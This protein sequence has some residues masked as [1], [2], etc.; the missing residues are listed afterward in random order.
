MPAAICGGLRPA[1]RLAMEAASAVGHRRTPAGLAVKVSVSVAKQ[2]AAQ[3]ENRGGEAVIRGKRSKPS[4]RRRGEEAR[5]PGKDVRHKNNR[6]RGM[7]R[8]G[9]GC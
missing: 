2:N 1:A 8:G 4:A 7:N 3:G 5:R 6:P 9:L